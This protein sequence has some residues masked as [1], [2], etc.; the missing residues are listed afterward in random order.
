MILAKALF[1]FQAIDQRVAEVGEVTTRFEHGRR[2]EDGRVDEH[3]VTFMCAAPA[4]ALPPDVRPGGVFLSYASDDVAAADRLYAA[5][6]ERLLE[7]GARLPTEGEIAARVKLARE[8]G[9]WL[10]VERAAMDSG[11]VM[12]WWE[13]L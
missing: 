10:T 1:A 4:V 12:A 3:D 8:S 7:R 9:R 11:L 5:L 13:G 2:T 6:Q